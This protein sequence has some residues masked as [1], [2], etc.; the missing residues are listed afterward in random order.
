MREQVSVF[1]CGSHGGS[2][3]E[4]QLVRPPRT[5]ASHSGRAGARS[6]AWRGGKTPTSLLSLTHHNTKH[7]TSTN[8]V[9]VKTHSQLTD[10]LKLR[11]LFQW[12]QIT[13]V[14]CESGSCENKRDGDKIHTP[15]VHVV[16]LLRLSDGMLLSTFT[17]GAILRY[18]HSLLFYSSTTPH[19]GG[20][21]GMFYSWAVI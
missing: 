1:T 14:P 16:H 19:F 21:N 18:F 10:Y 20:I 9:T 7:P 11:P 13:F 6:P 17:P 5:G 15:S 8:S 12:I 2:E 4:H 3:G